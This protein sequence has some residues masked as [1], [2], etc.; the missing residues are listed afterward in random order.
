MTMLIFKILCKKKDMGNNDNNKF[1]LPGSLIRIYISFLLL[2]IKLECSHCETIQETYFIKPSA[3]T[4]SEYNKTPHHPWSQTSSII[5]LEV[6]K[7]C[8]L[9]KKKLTKYS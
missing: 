6:E 3:A 1:Y 9:A 7:Y 4:L 5:I 2:I 8:I